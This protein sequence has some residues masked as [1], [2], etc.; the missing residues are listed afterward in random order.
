MK[1]RLTI[2]TRGI[3]FLMAIAVLAVCGILLPEL[4]REEAVANP[5]AGPAYPF[6]IAGWILALPIF[7]GLYQALKLIGFIEGDK[8]FSNRS[9]ATIKN[10]KTCA[11]AF[12]VMIVI[13]AITV[14]LITRGADPR[15][16]VTPVVSLGFIFTF[17]SIV[18][19]T[20]AAVLQRLLH[21]ALQI[22]SENDLT[23]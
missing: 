3:V 10:I 20:F 14:I 17:V 22:K 11:I 4:A 19:A 21:D 6:L 13:G 15:E 1:R 23:V 12:S 2:I 7:A 18:V 9:I 8:A 16:D 5:N